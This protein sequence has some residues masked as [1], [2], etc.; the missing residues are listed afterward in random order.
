MAVVNLLLDQCVSRLEFLS[1]EIGKG[2]DT[3]SVSMIL[4]I[5]VMDE[6][7]VVFENGITVE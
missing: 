5:V 6:V 4:S 3:D 7:L 2:I 1:S